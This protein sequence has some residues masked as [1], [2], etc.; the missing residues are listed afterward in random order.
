[1]KLYFNAMDS[2][3]ISDH[4]FKDIYCDLIEFDEADIRNKSF[5]EYLSDVD[6]P[7]SVLLSINTLYGFE[8]ESD[9]WN[10]TECVFNNADHSVWTMKALKEYYCKMILSCNDWDYTSFA[11]FINAPYN[12]FDIVE[13]AYAFIHEILTETDTQDKID[14]M[15][16]K[17]SVDDF[18]KE[19]IRHEN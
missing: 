4:T 5:K 16:M 8:F 13:N 19:A 1:M 3:I 15:H 17:K 12:D 10:C 11:E 2:V 18:I 7:G 14:L 6:T 9:L